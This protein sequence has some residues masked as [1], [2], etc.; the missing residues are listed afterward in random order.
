MQDRP[1]KPFLKIIMPELQINGA[2][3][4]AIDYIGHIRHVYWLM[5]FIVLLSL[6]LILIPHNFYKDFWYSIKAQGPLVSFVIVFCLISVSLMWS[7]GQRIDVWVFKVF[8]MSGQRSPWLDWS[9]LAITQLG[10]GVFA[11]FLALVLYLTGNNL[12]AYEL[13]LGTLTLWII[14]E[15]AKVLIQRARPFAN[16]KGVRIIGSKARGHS[17]PSGHTSQAFFITTLLTHYFNFS[18]WSWIGLYGVSLL[19]GITRIYVGMH[20][21]RDVVGGAMLGTAWGILGVI[22]NCYIWNFC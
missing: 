19:V 7:V 20:Y 11:V 22:I 12:V 17:F 14:V 18:V 6:F 16:L 15:L 9:M 10:S 4:K 21:P 8:N 3:K 5:F 2:C 1:K 13:I